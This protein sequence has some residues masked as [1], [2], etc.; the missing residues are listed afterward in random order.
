MLNMKLLEEGHRAVWSEVIRGD[1]YRLRELDFVPEL[2]VDV[3]ANVGSFT[4]HAKTLW[5]DAEVLAVEPHV[6]NAAIFRRVVGDTPG[7]ELLQMAIGGDGPVFSLDLDKAEPAR[8]RRVVH[9]FQVTEVWN[10]DVVF[11]AGREQV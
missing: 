2:V 10:K 1:T 11:Q 5:P 3:G 9:A 6:E 4:A 7:V 8:R